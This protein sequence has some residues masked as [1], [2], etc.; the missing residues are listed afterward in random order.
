MS[1]KEII[2]FE[3]CNYLFISIIINI[4]IIICYFLITNLNAT[5]VLSVLLS[6]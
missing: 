3:Q 5:R 2:D 4:I 1:S 6:M